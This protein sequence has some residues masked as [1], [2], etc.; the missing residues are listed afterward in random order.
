MKNKDGQK[1]KILVILGPTSSGKSDLGIVLAK[2]F[3]GEIISAD[4]RQVYRGLDIGTGKVTKAHMRGIRHYMIDVANPKRAFTAAQFKKHGE[5]VIARILKNGAL[6][7]IVGGTGFYIDALIDGILFPAVP[8]NPALRKKL[9][10]KSPAELFT[11]ILSLDQNRAHAIDRKNSRRL[12][13]AIEIASAIGITPE[14]KRCSPYRTLF[15]GIQT[16]DK[17]L[18]QKIE[19]RNA[20][21]FKR[22]IVA[23]IKK[24]HAQKLSWDRI[25]EF[26]FEYRHV[27]A[28]LR[29][30]CS[31]TDALDLMNTKTWQYAKRQRTWWKKNTK[32]QWFS[33]DDIHA[34]NTAITRFLKNCA[35]K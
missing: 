12:I 14:K 4:S 25:N 27:E 33:L 23:E 20:D 3:N 32:I 6:P 17:I 22:G 35:Q 9:S 30:E 7:I 21:M 2:K 1:P 5:K 24:L 15:I 19:K 11:L 29:G 28:F 26:G 13:R 18:K 31:K 8:P 34:I 10:K 16:N